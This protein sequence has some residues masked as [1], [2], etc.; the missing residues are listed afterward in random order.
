MINKQTDIEEIA[1]VFNQTPYKTIQD[2]AR[3]GVVKNN[4]LEIAKFIKNTF[5]FKKRSIGEYFSVSN[6]FTKQVLIEYTHF[7]NFKNL[8]LDEALRIYYNAFELPHDANKISLIVEILS[9]E[10]YK[11]NPYHFQSSIT[12]YFLCFHVVFLNTIFHN[13]CIAHKTSKNEFIQ[14]CGNIDHRKDLDRVLLEE[15][16]D[17]V[18]KEKI[19]IEYEDGTNNIISF[20]NPQIAG[21]MVKQGGRIKTWKRRWFL[22]SYHCLYYFKKYKDKEPCGKIPLGSV[23]I[24]I[25]KPRGKK[26]KYIVEIALLSDKNNTQ[27][28]KNFENKN[29]NSIENN[30][31]Y[32]ISADSEKA[33]MF[34]YRNLLNSQV[35]CQLEKLIQEKK[36][37]FLQNLK[38]NKFEKKLN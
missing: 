15:L 2:C 27:K 31:T 25:G 37:L 32:I 14:L 16:Y 4:P 38:R 23:D 19:I 29:E 33:Q 13:S 10:Y 3:S 24:N 34:W 17:G 35:G 22:L 30:R 20:T 9:N 8:R 26:H 1:K 6:E 12:V 5:S 28:K 21:F 11:Q 7:F 18:S 36:D